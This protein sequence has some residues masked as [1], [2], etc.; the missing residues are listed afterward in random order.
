MEHTSVRKNFNSNVALEVTTK[1]PSDVRAL[2][3]STVYGMEGKMQYRHKNASL[4]I[5]QLINPHFIVLRR[6][7]KLLG[8]AGFLFREITFNQQRIPSYYVRY[9]SIV[10]K[11]QSERKTRKNYKLGLIK[12]GLQEIITEHFSS[13]SDPA[14]LYSYIEEKNKFSLDLCELYGFQK[15]RELSTFIFSRVSPKKN[16]CVFLYE[17][18]DASFIQS[19]LAKEYKEY[20]FFFTEAVFKGGNYYVYKENEKIVAGI[21]AT[22][23]EWEVLNIPGFTGFLIQNLFPYL[24][25]LSRLFNSKS[26]RFVAFEA[27]F[28][29]EGSEDLLIKLM[30]SS[31][32]M[33][34][35]NLGILW[36]DSESELATKMKA[37]GDLGL[38]NKLKKDVP[39]NIVAKLINIGTKEKQLFFEQPAYISALD[40]S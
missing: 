1:A 30:E 4:R 16:P 17:E 25:L 37:S 31:C 40:L 10:N 6:A 34:N 21:K 33:E 13:K 28:C 9:L 15:I 39:A 26:M 29:E 20:N 19:Q 2:L 23:T 11:L 3:T 32:A 38:L 36:A 27:A 18:K 5:D 24:P 12:S 7:G 35:C 14:V 8:T 22:K